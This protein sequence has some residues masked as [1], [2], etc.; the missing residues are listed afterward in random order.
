MQRA[1]VLA[2]ILTGCGDNTPSNPVTLASGDATLVLAADRDSLTLARGGTTLLTFAPETFQAGTVDDL[3]AGDSFDP[4]YLFVADPPAPP[5]GLAWHHGNRFALVSASD[6]ELV[7]SVDALRVTFHPSSA[8][9]GFDAVLTSSAARTA[10]LRLGPDAGA[11]EAFYGLG[12]WAD[13]IDH[14]GQLRPMQMEL[15]QNSESMDD[16][17]HVP[18]PLLIGTAGWGLFVESKR[19]GAFD[20]ARQ[21]ATRVDIAFGTGADSPAG[22]AFHLFS[23]DQPLD[24]LG[25]YYAI[26]GAPGL[27]AP[28]ALGPLLW[29]DENANQAQV[30][31]DIDQIRTRHLAASGVWFDRPYATG[32]ET[33][34]WNPAKFSDPTSMLHALHDAGLRYAIW[35]APYTAGSS[36]ADPAQP[37]LD[38]ATAHGYFPPTTAVL[39]NGWGKPLD[40]TNAGAYAWWQSQLRT[41]TDTY[42][43]EGFKLDYAEDVVVGLLGRRTPWAFSDGSDELT[44]HYGYQLLYH[45]VHREVMPAA[46][47]FLLTR[48]GR[49]GDQVHGMIVWPGDLDASFAQQGD[50][51]PGSALGAVGG[52]PAALAK[53]LS[54]SASGFPFYASDT[55]G[56]RHSPASKECWIRWVEANAVWP[57]MNIGD[58]SSEQ[59]WEFTADNG[60]DAEALAD[61]AQYTLL[62]LRLYPYVWT[63]A[64]Q[65]AT[66]GRPIVRPL[67]LAYPELGVNPQDEYLLGDSILAAP[68]VTEGATSRTVVLPA[69][70]WLGWWDGQPYSA[71]IT[72]TADLDTLPLYIAA[73]GIVPM[74]RDTIETLAPVATGS[75]IDSFATDAGVLW[76]RVAPSTAPTQLGVYDGTLLQQ[77]P[78]QV[79]YAPGSV[80]TEGA[81]FEV[82][83]T[84]AA[85]AQVTDGATPLAQQASLAALQA[86]GSG[87]FY[88]PTATG[89]TLWIEV[90]SAATVVF[91]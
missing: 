81:L 48:T 46:G 19:P 30:L 73:G 68:I 8:P 5:N 25:S 87:W 67:G 66:T 51:L 14:R 32:V 31:D 88:D 24:V 55:A 33:F 36:N 28:W 59:P 18:V 37:E 41:Y 65:I 26:A 76:V 77:Q 47:G 86:A 42:G 23:A 22:L 82:I 44:M 85:P 78:R 89:G 79:T 91:Q 63:Y 57:A 45:Q 6:S 60:R 62:H 34:D 52:L 40:F 21:S 39:L 11:S 71:T 35:Q 54:L 70:T 84:P 17:N 69:G 1:L 15:D 49:W 61:Y 4:Y 10:Y 64:Q 58:A 90:A 38:Y 74:L 7:V 56:Y 80:F 29:R 43:V 50:P 83:A 75:S 53:G 13:A 9:G 12:E 2:A 27:P 72:A 20:V 3:D 16:E